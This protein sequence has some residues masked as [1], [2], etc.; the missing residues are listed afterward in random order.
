MFV[1]LDSGLDFMWAYC[2]Y[3]LIK[4]RTS[5]LRSFHHLFI[6]NNTTCKLYF[7]IFY[8]IHLVFTDRL[9]VVVNTQF[10]EFCTEWHLFGCEWRRLNRGVTLCSRPILVSGFLRSRREKAKSKKEIKK[11]KSNS[12]SNSVKEDVKSDG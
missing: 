11:K 1:S 4:S 7:H 3:E 5:D 2:K 10:G 8:I 9:W 6:L 12:E